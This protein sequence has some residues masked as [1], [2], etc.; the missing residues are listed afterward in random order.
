MS[1]EEEYMI[2]QI[3]R[4]INDFLKTLSDR[5]SFIFIC[6][7][8]CS[9]RISDIADMLHVSKRTVFTRLSSIRA[10]LKEIFV[11]EGYFDE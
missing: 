1:A 9:D 5:D 2:S 6:R 8:Y 11:R 10:E 7:Y 4:I 3:S